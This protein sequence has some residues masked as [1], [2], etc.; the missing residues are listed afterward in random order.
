MN[1]KRKNNLNNIINSE[2]ENN[3]KNEKEGILGINSVKKIK[4]V[5]Q[6]NDDKKI[7]FL[8]EIENEEGNELIKDNIFM[9]KI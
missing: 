1:K 6:N 9:L 4:N 2:E 8:I 5:Y 7:L 3:K